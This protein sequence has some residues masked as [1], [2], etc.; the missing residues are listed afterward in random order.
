M[1]RKARI[2]AFAAAAGLMALGSCSSTSVMG[3]SRASYVDGELE[4]LN[5]RTEEMESL[6]S[7]LDELSGLSERVDA[8]DEDMA[9]LNRSVDETRE[10]EQELRSLAGEFERRLDEMPENTLRELVEAILDRLD[11]SGD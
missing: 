1:K 8:L 9:D 6:R 2:A 11:G 4:E 3:L 10:T 7:R 5:A